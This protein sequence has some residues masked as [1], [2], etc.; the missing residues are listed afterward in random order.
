MARKIQ[1]AGTPVVGWTPVWEGQYTGDELESG[2]DLSGDLGECPVPVYLCTGP[3]F[4]G[5]PAVDARVV[6]G[7]CDSY[8]PLSHW[9]LLE[10]VVV[11]PAVARVCRGCPLGT[12]RPQCTAGVFC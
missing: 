8:C 9:S 2:T 6:F 10:T 11:G 7:D 12:S 3:R 5:F 4:L 1:C